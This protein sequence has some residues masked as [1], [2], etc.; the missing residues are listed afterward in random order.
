[1]INIFA[2]IQFL[3]DKAGQLLGSKIQL[4][5]QCPIQ[6]SHVGLSVILCDYIVVLAKGRCSSV[7]S[8]KEMMK[9][10]TACESQ[11][12]GLWALL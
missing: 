3:P 7:L 9:T 6:H 4:K 2:W 10:V 1:M 5:L 12:Y 11:F 8:F